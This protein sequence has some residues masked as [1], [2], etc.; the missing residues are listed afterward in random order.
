MNRNFV[1]ISNRVSSI[2]SALLTEF[3][4]SFVAFVF[5][6]RKGNQQEVDIN[7]AASRLLTYGIPLHIVTEEYLKSDIFLHYLRSLNLDFLIVHSL[8]FLLPQRMLDL[9]RLSCLNLHPSLLPAYRGPDPWFWQYFDELKT[10]GFTVHK[11][12]PKEDA[13]DILSQQK[14]PMNYTMKQST[15]SEKML[16]EIGA[17]LLCRTILNYDN[18]VPVRQTECKKNRRARSIIDYCNDPELKCM[19]SRQKNIINT[20]YPGLLGKKRETTS[21]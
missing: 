5:I 20:V 21:K 10:S 15:F 6:A 8:H 1:F 17:P 7:S 19:S 14:F 16:E 13:G 4:D 11:M 18:I 9:P 12:S 2:L 3:S